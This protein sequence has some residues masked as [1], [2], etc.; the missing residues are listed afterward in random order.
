MVDSPVVEAIPATV[1][2]AV[3]ALQGEVDALAGS[4][5]LLVGAVL[6]TVDGLLAGVGLGTAS[7]TVDVDLQAALGSLLTTPLDSGNGVV[8][9]L[10]AGTVTVDLAQ[11]ADLN[12][13]APNTELL[14]TAVLQAI[15]AEVAALVD[16]LVQDIETAVTNALDAATVAVD[17]I[18]TAPVVGTDLV[19]ITVDGTLA[20]ISDGSAVVGISALGIPI[21]GLD[22]AAVLAGLKPVVDAVLDPVTGALGT[23][24]TT[25]NDQVVVPVTDTLNPAIE[26]VNEVV[27]LLANVQEPTPPVAGQVFTETA[28]RLSLLPSALLPQLLVLDLAQATVGPDAL[29]GPPVIASLT[30]NQGPTA[31]GTPVTISGTDLEGAS[32]VLVDV[33]E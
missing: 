1:T 19:H 18:L 21:V 7:A 29:V 13:L 14:S 23:L 27:S 2:T 31:G 6:D 5:G 16:G 22:S 17:V 30:P 33:G 28:V 26:L 15:T 25:L 12:A 8:I 32:D 10:A 4:D 20:D 3:G 11:F 24:L 9:D